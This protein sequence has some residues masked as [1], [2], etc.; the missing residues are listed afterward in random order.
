MFHRRDFLRLF[1]SAGLVSLS[2]LPPRFLTR[3]FADD[4]VPPGP[5]RRVLVLIQLAGG[6]DGLNTVIPF[7][8]DEYYRRRPGIGIPGPT[9]LKL[10]DQ[11]GLHPSLTGLQK[12][13]DA[14]RLAIVQGVGYPHPDRSHFRS[15]D[16]WHS[17]QPENETPADGWLGRALEW[18]FD[19]AKAGEGLALGVERLP[20]ALVSG[21]IPVPTL[22]RIEDWKL[23]E[24]NPSA[25]NRNLKRALVTRSATESARG[26]LE[27]LRK[28]TTT[29][30]AAADRLA[31]LTKD[32]QP[33]AEYP[34]SHL[35][36]QLKLVAQFIAADAPTRIFFVSLDG[37]DTHS[38]QQP[39]HTALLTQLSA[40]IAAFQ[41]DL[42]G[43]GLGDRVMTATFSEFGRRVEENGSLGTDHGA[44]SMLFAVTPEGKGGFYGKMPSL[45]TLTDGD[46]VFNTDFRQIYATWLDRWLGIASEAVLGGKYEAVPF[47]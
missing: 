43:H 20:L 30:I 14:G 4:A 19:H 25:N 40:A 38:Q 39:G 26:E 29:A 42:D 46:L 41:A 24:G 33:A 12:L 35:A 21:R 3:A 31:S 36:R 5:D 8:D 27:F 2:G 34:E 13:F 6:N 9:V 44:A 47:A 23:A 10:N 7:A 32:Y 45:T 1:G 16:I 37:F 28:S 11:F 15:M 17:A 22:R 18:Q